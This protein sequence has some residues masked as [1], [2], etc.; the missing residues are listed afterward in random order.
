[1]TD[2]TRLLE[3]P[4]EAATIVQNCVLLLVENIVWKK[5]SEIIRLVSTKKNGKNE[6]MEKKMEN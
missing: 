3:N 6:K 1:M 2:V 5:I 4:V